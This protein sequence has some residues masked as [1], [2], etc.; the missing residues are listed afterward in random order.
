MTVTANFRRR[1]PAFHTPSGPPGHLP[2]FAEKG[3]TRKLVF[4]RGRVQDRSV[5]ISIETPGM[6]AGVKE[7][8]VIRADEA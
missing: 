5:A 3:V 6:R 7:P 4:W 2:R 8:W 1:I